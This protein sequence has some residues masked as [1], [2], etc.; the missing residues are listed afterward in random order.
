[1]DYS[2]QGDVRPTVPAPSK[3]RRSAPWLLGALVLVLLALLLAQQVFGMWTVF[4]PEGAA[5]VLILYGLSSLIFVAFII[6]SFILLRTLLK[7]RRERRESLLGSSIKTRL[8][9]YFILGSLLPITAMATFSFFFLNRSLEKWFNRLPEDV[10]HEAHAARAYDSQKQRDDL[11]DEVALIASVVNAGQSSEGVSANFDE[12]R[13]RSRFAGLQIASKDGAVLQSSVDSEFAFDT[14]DAGAQ[15][16]QIELEKTMS[17]ALRIY[18][19]RGA[20]AD[21]RVD[22]PA[23]HV[24]ASPLGS[25]RTL[26]A[27]RFFESNRSLDRIVEGSETFALLRAR[28]RRVRMVG[29]STLGLMTLLLLFAA[30]WTALHLADSIAAPIR[31]LAEA[32]DEVARGNLAHRVRAASNDELALLAESF[33]GMTAQ[34]E[35]N[36]QRIEAGATELRE[37]NG[38]LAERRNYI[39]TILESLSTGVVSLDERNRVTTINAAALLILR[40][41]NPPPPEAAL[42]EIV[43]AEDYAVLNRVVMRARRAGRA[44]E[45]THLARA[46][47]ASSENVAFV[48]IAISATVLKA[49]NDE[50]RGAVIV[51]EDLTE[52]LHAQR[53]AAWS[54]VARRMAHEIKNPLTPIQLSAERIRRYFRKANE[55]NRSTNGSSQNSNAAAKRGSLEE[56]I[57]TCT[58]TITREVSSLKT[59]VDEFAHFARLPKVRL[60]L[61]DLNQVVRQAITLYEERLNDVQMEVRLAWTLPP[62]MLDANQI[63]R[64]LINLID[65]ALEALADVE[66]ERRIRIATGHDPARGLLLVEVADTGHGI[67]AND[68]QRLFQPY[69]STRGRGTG[70]GLAIVNRIIAEH[71]G[72]IHAAS[73]H[74]RGA[75]FVIELMAAEGK[76]NDERGTVSGR[77]QELEDRSQDENAPIL[78][79]NS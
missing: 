17:E 52:L 31:S 70:L 38:A 55:D 8:V 39:E 25:E 9:V 19:E 61:G 68:F 65:N 24:A 42:S 11:R 36:R 57:E 56:L 27:A 26:L 2:H 49:E 4:T 72:R 12:L 71:D 43:S 20:E 21:F 53:A 35:E 59:M 60:E 62:L 74:P 51:I 76:A 66:G 78:T 16:N 1:M 50:A 32:A 3:R 33:N 13:R 7:L 30:T 22:N 34:L 40:L 14:A 67:G 18:V 47:V 29:L 63:R 28:Q 75:K 37:K 73:N 10:V 6:F 64:V 23:F 69:F 79:P 54:E 48:P 15:Q 45:Q 41:N 58:T 5:E 46:G 77:S 44:A